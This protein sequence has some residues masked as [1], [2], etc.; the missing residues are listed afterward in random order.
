MFCFILFLN[1]FFNIL[2]PSPS[3]KRLAVYNQKQQKKNAALT[4]TMISNR[5]SRPD[6]FKSSEKKKYSTMGD[7]PRSK[8]TIDLTMVASNDQ[9][10]VTTDDS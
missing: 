6:N 2:L 4:K 10:P 5:F 1:F 3:E 9:K 7:S 8:A